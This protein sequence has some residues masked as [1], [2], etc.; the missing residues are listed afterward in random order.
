[1]NVADI[2]RNKTGDV[3]GTGADATIGDAAKLL[4]EKGIGAAVVTGADGQLVGIISERDIVRGLAQRGAS[5]LDAPVSSLM[6]TEVQTC[7]PDDAVDALM[8][9]MTAGRFRHLPVM[10]D[11][12]LVHVISIGDLVKSRLGELEFEADALK[13]YISGY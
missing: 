1:M 2:L 12:T 13:Q 8:G 7:T 4:A 9:R 11:G 10:Q 3:V 6:T 5:L